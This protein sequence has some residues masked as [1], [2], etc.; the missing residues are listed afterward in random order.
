MHRIYLM[1]TQRSNLSGEMDSPWSTK[2]S[3]FMNNKNL[4][5]IFWQKLFIYSIYGEESW[6]ELSVLC[7]LAPLVYCLTQSKK[8][9]FHLSTRRLRLAPSSQNYTI[10]IPHFHKTNLIENQDRNFHYERQTPLH[11]SAI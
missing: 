11:L 5:A 8:P 1:G 6:T 2:D 7:T 10:C 3:D 4:G 9:R